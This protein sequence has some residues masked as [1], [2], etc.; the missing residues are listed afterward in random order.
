VKPMKERL[1]IG[2]QT[3]LLSCVVDDNVSKA[4]TYH[5]EKDGKKLKDED[6]SSLTN[7][8]LVTSGFLF[9]A[10]P[11]ITKHKKHYESRS[12]GEEAILKCS[13]T[14]Y[15]P[16]E[17]K[18]YK[19][20]GG[21]QPFISPDASESIM[22]RVHRRM[23]AVIVFLIIVA[24]VVILIVIIF[25]YEKYSKKRQLNL[26]GKQVQNKDD[27]VHQRNLSQDL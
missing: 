21:F 27:G 8:L 2:N 15:P 3:L 12:E 6:H 25:T 17:W 13:C 18:W 14:G 16:A 20:G 5:W 22:L 24:E 4:F 7:V 9:A 10:A 1:S 19:L 11:K 26:H 23:D